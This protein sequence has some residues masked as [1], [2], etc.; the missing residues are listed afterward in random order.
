MHKPFCAH[1][2]KNFDE[3]LAEYQFQR[4][5]PSVVDTFGWRPT[6]DGHSIQFVQAP[7]TSHALERLAQLAVHRAQLGNGTRQD[8]IESAAALLQ[9][10]YQANPTLI[11]VELE[12]QLLAPMDTEL[13][14]D[15]A[16]WQQLVEQA[17]EWQM[18]GASLRAIQGLAEHA[19]AGEFMAPM[20]FLSRKLGDPRPIIRYAALQAVAEI[21]PQLRFAGADKA[22]ETALEMTSLGMGPHTLVIGLKPEMRQAASQLLVGQM[23]SPVTEANSGQSALQALNGL[24]P[25]ELIILV[26]RVSD[27]SI[28]ELL[29]RLRKTKHGQSLPIAVLTDELYQ[30]ERRL[31]GEMS[32]VVSSVLSYDGAHM[33][34][35]VNRMLDT[36]DTDTTVGN[37]SCRTRANRWQFFGE[38]CQR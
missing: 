27:M 2:Q 22:V 16:Y 13:A 31:M 7:Q 8:R 11:A 24:L 36:L 32:G 12:S 38:D 33:D 26:D 14:S 29:Q 1:L 9:R 37:R 35:I 18:H 4:G 17:D 23:D 30:H 20:D 6:A 5:T 10:A 28:Y 3:A 15:A 21:D 19:K 34:R 25:I